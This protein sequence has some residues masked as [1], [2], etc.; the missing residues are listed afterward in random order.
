[1]ASGGPLLMW[2]ERLSRW[3]LAG[4]MLVA[5]LPKL[6]SPAAFAEVIGAYGLL[7]D[8]L[9]LP[10]AILLPVTELAA[11]ALL[12]IGR[13]AGLWLT[14]LLMVLF[15]A[16]LGYGI[17]L[18]LDIDCG[19]FGPEDPEHHAFSGLRTALLRDVLYCIP[20]AF[21]LWRTYHFPFF[22]SGERK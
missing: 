8:S 20:I 17:H 7:P 15:I 18:G 2:L 11:A 9:L 12:L 4:V 14:T 16:V 19:C 10:A 6:T 3:F 13:T 5:G 22:F 21:C 1:M